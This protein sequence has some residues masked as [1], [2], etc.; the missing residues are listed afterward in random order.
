MLSILAGNTLNFNT[1]SQLFQGSWE[2]CKCVQGKEEDSNVIL[3]TM[4]LLGDGFHL[5]KYKNGANL[6]GRGRCKDP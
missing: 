3:N 4:L 6:W 5:P 1:P 2:N